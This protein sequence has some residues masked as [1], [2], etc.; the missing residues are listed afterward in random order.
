MLLLGGAKP[1]L[2]GEH[3]EI[4][5]GDAGQR[6]QRNHIA[7]EAVGDGGFL[8]GLR[9]VAVLAPEIEFIA[10]AERCRIV[11]DLASAIGQAA[12]ARARGPGIGLL[13]VAVQARQQRRAGDTR[14]RVGLDEARG[15]GR[16]VQIDRLGFLHQSGQFPRTESAPPIQRRRRIRVGQSRGFVTV[17]NVQR[18]IGNI[19]GQDAARRTRDNAQRREPSRRARRPAK[20]PRQPG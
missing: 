18:G 10:G 14:L 8:G 17:G 12:G 19:L 9:G 20:R 2:R 15:G 6:G 3:L 11:D 13:T 7:I 4:G 1:V 16:D 5:I